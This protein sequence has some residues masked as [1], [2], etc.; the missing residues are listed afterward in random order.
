MDLFTSSE[1][2]QSL[3]RVVEEAASFKM[4]KNEIMMDFMQSLPIPT[5]RDMDE[6]YKELYTLKKMVKDL[7]K[8]NKQQ[9]S[10]AQ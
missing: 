4:S 6:V 9:E 2:R 10:K 1:W 3:C 8:K 5:N 7:L